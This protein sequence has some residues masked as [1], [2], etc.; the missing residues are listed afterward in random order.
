MQKSV[1]Q[2]GVL[3]RTLGNRVDSNGKEDKDIDN[4]T[5]ASKGINGNE[6]EYL[7]EIEERQ[8]KESMFTGTVAWTSMRLQLLAHITHIARENADFNTAAKYLCAM[9]RLMGALEARQQDQLTAWSNST[10][11]PERDLIRD[12]DEY[13]NGDGSRGSP[14][15]DLQSE[16]GDENIRSVADDIG[17]VSVG[18]LLGSIDGRRQLS[19]ELMNYRYRLHSNGQGQIHTEAPT[20]SASNIRRLVGSPSGKSVSGKSM[21]GIMGSTEKPPRALHRSSSIGSQLSSSGAGGGIGIGLG[22]GG[23]I[24]VEGVAKRGSGSV[25]SALCSADLDTKRTSFLTPA[26]ASTP[27]S[28]PGR[29]SLGPNSGALVPHRPS[30]SIVKGERKEISK[31]DDRTMT[32][33]SSPTEKNKRRSNGSTMTSISN[34][35]KSQNASV[36]GSVSSSSC[37]TVFSPP[38]ILG[39]SEIT[40]RRRKKIQQ[41]KKKKPHSTAGRLI[42]AQL[43]SYQSISNT[44]SGAANFLSTMLLPDVQSTAM[45]SSKIGVQNA[46]PLGILQT[47]ANL[48]QM[49]VNRIKLPSA[50]RISSMV[51]NSAPG[52]VVPVAP[53]SKTP[54]STPD[55][56]TTITSAS[57]SVRDREELALIVEGDESYPVEDMPSPSSPLNRCLD[58]LSRM[59]FEGGVSSAQ[60]EQGI[61][62]LEQLS[63]EVILSSCLMFYLFIHS[64]LFCVYAYSSFSFNCFFSLL[65]CASSMYS[66]LISFQQENVIDVVIFVTVFIN[67]RYLRTRPS[68]SPLSPCQCAL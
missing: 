64:F 36:A 5:N 45:S 34:F 46:T 42:D 21:S 39:I 35:R 18:R 47:G 54:P 52:R 41:N 23:G 30:F 49:S 62:L 17:V 48:S 16:V 56:V 55:T 57:N 1:A 11:L 7:V 22:G 13:L 26:G 50:S 9:I 43:Q 32:A 29:Y 58:S 68:Y 61:E 63:R 31:Y 25:H 20:L 10:A 51:L 37:Y 2:Y 24:G 27:G 8:E 65:R 38:S 4:D 60:Q 6:H 19:T 3:T 59:L 15:G 14:Y 33:E 53:G 66:L 40:E 28:G 67:F 12:R 44:A